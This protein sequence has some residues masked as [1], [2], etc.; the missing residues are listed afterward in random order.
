MRVRRELRR[1]G[2]CVVCGWDVRSFSYASQLSHRFNIILAGNRQPFCGKIAAVPHGPAR[3]Q[4]QIVVEQMKE[5][6]LES[7]ADVASRNVVSTLLHALPHAGD[8]LRGTGEPEV[9]K[10]DF[11]AKL[12]GAAEQADVGPALKVLS[13]ANVSRWRR[14]SS[15][16]VSSKRAARTA[17]ALGFS[18]ES[19]RAI[20]SAFRKRRHFTSLG[21]NSFA[22]VVLPA[23]LQPAMR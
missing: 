23:P 16:W 4:R 10:F 22:K 19:P 6:T 21:R 15:T 9:V 1:P 3:R 12:P 14:H 20:S 7:A 18:G 2:L 11:I 17:L 8:G 5:A 13:K